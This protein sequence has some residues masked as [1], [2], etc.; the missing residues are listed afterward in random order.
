MPTRRTRSSSKDETAEE[1]NL[2]QEDE[3]VEIA[4]SDFITPE[5][6]LS[7]D[8]IIFQAV[9]KAKKI[10]ENKKIEPAGDGIVSDR[11]VNKLKKLNEKIVNKLGLGGTRSYKV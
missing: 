3:V 8:L 11:Q 2:Q 9:E 10:K 1:N 6:Q 4:E 5:P 7:N